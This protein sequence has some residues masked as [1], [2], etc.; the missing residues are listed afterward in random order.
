[1]GVPAVRSEWKCLVNEFETLHWEYGATMLPRC[2]IAN[3][4]TNVKLLKS[5]LRQPGHCCYTLVNP[6]EVHSAVRMAQGRI[7]VSWTLGQFLLSKTFR[8]TTQAHGEFY[9]TQNAKELVCIITSHMY[10][11]AK[12]VLNTISL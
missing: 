2:M 6:A 10:L 12:D 4:T 5:V 9:S 1:M 11:R 3:I 8:V 7:P